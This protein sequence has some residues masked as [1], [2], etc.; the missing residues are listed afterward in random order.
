VE[1]SNATTYRPGHQND[2]VALNRTKKSA[3][4]LPS[5]D[6]LWTGPLIE[7]MTPPQIVSRRGAAE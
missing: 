5:G 4:E 2:R 3:V 1:V 7:V 6:P